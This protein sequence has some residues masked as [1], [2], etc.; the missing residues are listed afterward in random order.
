M[1]LSSIRLNLT[2]STEYRTFLALN[3][4]RVAVGLLLVGLRTPD[5]NRIVDPDLYHWLTFGYGTMGFLLGLTPKRF[6]THYLNRCI[7]RF[8]MLFTTLLVALN[9]GSGS[10]MALVL[11]PMLTG[12]A[13]SSQGR[14]ALQDAALATALIFGVEVWVQ[15]YVGDG[16]FWHALGAGVSYLAT[17]MLA[18][19]L[20]MLLQAQRAMVEQ[21]GADL[22]SLEQLNQHIIH[23]M[24]TGMIVVD[25]KGQVYRHNHQAERLLGC[26]EPYQTPRRYLQDYSV[27][28]AELYSRWCAG[29]NLDGCTFTVAANQRLIHPRWIL[30][31]GNGTHLHNKGA[32]IYLEDLHEIQDHAQR[33]KLAALGR[34]TA[35][36]A[37]EIRNPLSSI[38]Y[39]TELLHEQFSEDDAAAN[40]AS[41]PHAFTRIISQNVQ[42]I[43]HIVEEVMQLN[44]RDRAQPE[45]LKLEE[46]IR[47]LIQEKTQTGELVPNAICLTFDP[48][49]HIW[50]DRFHL[51]RILWNLIANAWRHSQQK[52][53]SVHIHARLG[54]THEV[55]VIDVMDDGAGIPAELQSRL[56]EPFSTTHRQGNGLGLYIARE[57]TEANHGTLEY[58]APEDIARIPQTLPGAHFRIILPC[59]QLRASS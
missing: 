25:D 32:I 27:P 48:D 53:E 17:A 3:M 6:V 59:T 42:R 41:S 21:Q 22:A 38:R 19:R 1:K 13:V 18:E 44:Q 33:M 30:L 10:G 52:A 15:H 11:L 20:G 39:A 29:E 16:H 2:I 43:N 45:R 35:N 51:E 50:C 9:F 56:F 8:D 55:T 24:P 26:L 40:H 37:H 7:L 4:Y 14:Q 5:T 36:I 46:L 49:L 54:Y 57:L 31:Q 23:D 47:Y 58:L 34:L 12:I 28:L